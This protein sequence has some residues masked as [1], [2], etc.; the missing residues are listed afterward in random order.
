MVFKE[1]FVFFG[2]FIG[3]NWVDGGYAPPNPA[4]LA[5]AGVRGGELIGAIERVGTVGF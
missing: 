5:A 1:F 3:R 4:P 2:V